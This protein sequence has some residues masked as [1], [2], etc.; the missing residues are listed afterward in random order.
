MS[1]N[2]WDMCLKVSKCLK[3]MKGS[4]VVMKDMRKNDLYALR[5]GF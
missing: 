3:L 2:R 4:M 5:R 1:L